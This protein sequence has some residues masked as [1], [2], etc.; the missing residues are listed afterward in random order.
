MIVNTPGITSLQLP[1]LTKVGMGLQILNIDSLVSLE[2]PK[3]ASVLQNL[4]MQG[5]FLPNSLETI[6]F[7]ALT[8][9]GGDISIMQ[10][11]NLL[12]VKFPALTTATSFGIIAEPLLTSVSA[13]HLQGTA[14]S[15][16]LSYNP[17][18]TEIDLSA[19]KTIGGQL[20]LEGASS[21]ANLNGLKSL[22]TVGTD[23]TL[24]S[25]SSLTDASGMKGLQSVGNNFSL[26][27]LSV[28]AD[29]DLA[30]FTA[31]KNVGGDLTIDGVPF[32][33]FNGFA[34]SNVRDVYVF[35]SGVTSI[36]NIDLSKL[37]VSTKIWVMGIT[38]GAT[39][40]G[41]ASFN[42][43]LNVQSSDV[44]LSGFTTV[45]DVSCSGADQP[46]SATL[47]LPF[48]KV[49]GSLSIE[50]Q[51]YTDIQASALKEIDGLLTISG[52]GV[53]NMGLTDLNGFASLTN[54]QGVTIQYNQ[55]LKDFTGLQHALGSF[56]AG[57]WLVSNNSYNPTY[58]DMADGKY[59]GP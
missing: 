14:G 22:T 34:L 35:A 47:S 50:V 23:F 11:S 5:Y 1:V 19:L 25:L 39:L 9:V 36:R 32:R 38:G 46:S 40:K 30:S 52:Q 16:D 57:K 27:G 56:G 44:A 28:L 2:F 12:T 7:P 20:H 21:L 41:P 54:V 55:A 17:A 6:S 24:A 53:P 29:D 8:T 43:E 26:Q 45:G 15:V 31:L 58:Q 59:V 10:W 13:P 49:T 37:Q 42:G 18:L 51:G 3:L 33:N 48:R 4:T